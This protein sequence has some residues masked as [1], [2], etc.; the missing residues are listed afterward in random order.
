MLSLPSE[1]N[2][3]KV[4]PTIN[5]KLTF[6]TKVEILTPSRFHI[7]EIYTFATANSN[8]EKGSLLTNK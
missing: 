7:K 6:A 2:I 4:L 5:T 8:S 3:N 1:I